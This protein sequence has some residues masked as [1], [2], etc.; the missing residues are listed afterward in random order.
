MENLNVNSF[1]LFTGAVPM[2]NVELFLVSH[3]MVCF[4]QLLGCEVYIII[5]IIIIFSTQEMW[6]NVGDHTEYCK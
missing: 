2:L 1:L 4:H 3:Q 6:C 5:I